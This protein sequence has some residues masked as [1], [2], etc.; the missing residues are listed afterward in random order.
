MARINNDDSR[1][2]DCNKGSRSRKG[3]AALAVIRG[4]K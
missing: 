2:W 1:Y 4:G 3:G